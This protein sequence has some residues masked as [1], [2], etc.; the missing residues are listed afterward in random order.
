MHRHM[1]LQEALMQLLI[2][3]CFSC[4][5]SIEP[6]LTHIVCVVLSYMFAAVLCWCRLEV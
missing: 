1:L 4:C 2:V 3:N 5:I 6:M